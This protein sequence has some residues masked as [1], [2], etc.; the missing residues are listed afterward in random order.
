MININGCDD[1][2]YRY[3]MEIIQVTNNGS[4]NGQFTIIKN[5]KH[6]EKS[7]NTPEEILFK[8][9]A[10]SLGSSYNNKK[11]ALNGKYTQ[12]H[13]QE[14]IFDYI[15]CFVIC[16]NCGIP[17]LT[18]IIIKKKMECKCSA[19][20]KIIKLNIKTKNNIKGEEIIFNYLKNDK[21][22]TKSKGSMVFQ[23][24]INIELSYVPCSDK[25]NIDELFDSLDPFA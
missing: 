24:D 7:I 4:G 8:Y 15:N 21:E 16:I 20:G 19:C 9:L 2:F 12:E 17:E 23:N 10:H 18:Y 5:M 25:E 11:S 6:I 1:S 3:K 22:W 14:K 13:I